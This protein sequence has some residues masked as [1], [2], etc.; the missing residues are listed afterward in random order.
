MKYCQNVYIQFRFDSFGISRWKLLPTISFR[1]VYFLALCT[2]V[3]SLKPILPTTVKKTIVI[4][5]LLRLIFENCIT[6]YWEI[7]N[8]LLML[9]T[10]RL[11]STTKFFLIEANVG[12]G[13]FSQLIR[14]CCTANDL[15]W[16]LICKIIK[17][18]YH[19]RGKLLPSLRQRNYLCRIWVALLETLLKS[20]DNAWIDR[21]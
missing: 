18:D 19:S 7:G 11:E 6:I 10:F 8:Y 2:K 13:N 21:I 3:L 20:N 12:N 9:R 15:I 14:R 4:A 5:K 17:N 16:I 1:C